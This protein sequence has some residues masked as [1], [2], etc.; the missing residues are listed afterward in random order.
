MI[1][2]TALRGYWLKSDII[3]LTKQAEGLILQGDHISVWIA[4]S[5]SVLKTDP[6]PYLILS[7]DNEMGI[8]GEKI[9]ASAL[10]LI[11][12]VPP[13][14]KRKIGNDLYRLL[15]F[16]M[17]EDPSYRYSTK[18][19][20]EQLAEDI[21]LPMRLV[22]P[23]TLT[24]LSGDETLTDLLD[25]YC[26]PDLSLNERVYEMMPGELEKL[27]KELIIRSN[28]ITSE[29]EK[30][31]G[32]LG[33][34]DIPEGMR[35]ELDS[36]ADCPAVYHSVQ[37]PKQKD[38][39]SY[40][41]HHLV[42]ACSSQVREKDTY[43][44]D[45]YVRQNITKSIEKEI[46]QS[47]IDGVATVQQNTIE[48]AST[49]SEAMDYYYR[50]PNQDTS[51]LVL[52]LQTMIVSAFEIGRLSG[53]VSSGES[54]QKAEEGQF[55]D[56][57][58]NPFRTLQK[59]AVLLLKLYSTLD[60]K[61][62]S[63]GKYSIISKRWLNTKPGFT[64]I[65]RM[66]GT[67]LGLHPVIS[68]KGDCYWGS[69]SGTQWIIYDP[70]KMSI[71]CRYD[72]PDDE[73]YRPCYTATKKAIMNYERQGKLHLVGSH[74][75]CGSIIEGE[76]IFRKLQDMISKNQS[77]WCDVPIKAERIF[78]HYGIK[79]VVQVYESINLYNDWFLLWKLIHDLPAIQIS[80]LCNLQN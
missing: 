57:N 24:T 12:L 52:A 80:R 15:K 35:S 79:F 30:L 18:S 34:L 48:L 42:P 26:P 64:K 1:Q 19:I 11:G 38:S 6:F 62:V 49:I 3:S 43:T 56:Q 39:Q 31:Q 23:N 72:I 50:S 51:T 47:I 29:I 53:S 59:E 75:Y 63:L 10:T 61:P 41:P 78:A 17:I 9:R 25:H 16:T 71:N 58:T 2:S 65:I 33:D 60:I 55:V 5:A 8:C 54:T 20:I 7:L 37:N 4:V 44:K 14:L 77:P 40:N 74:T 66:C 70:A 22:K 32:I 68:V 21:P 13:E 69:S 27:R 73:L 28:S 36:P 46:H 67:H 76:T 45:D